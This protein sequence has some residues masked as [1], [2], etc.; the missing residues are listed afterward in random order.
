M[1]GNG[2]FPKEN[3]HVSLCVRRTQVTEIARPEQ[4][5]QGKETEESLTYKMTLFRSRSGHYLPRP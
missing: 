4:E 3:K 2:E 5:D 1:E